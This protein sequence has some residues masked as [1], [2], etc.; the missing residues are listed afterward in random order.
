MER[1]EYTPAGELQAL[2]FP[3]GSIQK[4]VF[5]RGFVK[6]VTMNGKLI[7]RADATNVAAAATEMSM[8]N[9]DKVHTTFNQYMQLT[10]IRATGRGKTHFEETLHY[11]N[12]TGK[13]TR[14][15]RG[16]LGISGHY[17]YDAWGR[18]IQASYRKGN[19]GHQ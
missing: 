2:I 14:V 3:N 19:A 16:D 17:R 18:L 7:A 5:Q 1:M 4:S 10:K 9:G 6:E 11:N 13:V 15:D 12:R 8:G